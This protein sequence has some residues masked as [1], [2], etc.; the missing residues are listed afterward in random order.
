MKVRGTDFVLYQVTDIERS[1]AFY[2]DTLGLRLE[3]RLEGF[4][5]AEFTATPTTLALYQPENVTSEQT[6]GGVSIVLAV[7]NVVEAMKELKAKG[8]T[9]VLEAM[10]TPVC[11]MGCIADPDGNLIGL[12][13]RK[14][15]TFG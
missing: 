15:G 2:R 12:H 6:G 9:I 4:P 3:S 14:D 13:Q 10:E 5:W 8:V 1:I 7:D 11:W